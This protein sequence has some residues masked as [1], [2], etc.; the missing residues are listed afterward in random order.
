[1][2][3]AYAATLG[4]TAF[5]V[6]A[7]RGIARGDLVSEMIGPGLGALGMFTFIGYLVGAT[8]DR[9]IRQAIESQFREAVDKYG[10]DLANRISK[11]KDS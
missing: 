3:R 8:C 7:L 11:K 4:A 5:A 2:A 6:L 9:L 1:M 10:Q